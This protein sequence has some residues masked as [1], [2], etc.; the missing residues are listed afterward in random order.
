MMKLTVTFHNY[1]NTPKKGKE[2]DRKSHI[3]F[4]SQPTPHPRDI[5]CFGFQRDTSKALKAE[6]AKS[7]PLHMNVHVH[8]CT[9]WNGIWNS[10]RLVQGGSNMTG[11]NCDLFT[12]KQSQSCLNHLVFKN[13]HPLEFSRSLRIHLGRF[14]YNT[15]AKVSIIKQ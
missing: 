15:Y 10:V 4:H 1:A 12:H 8:A 11:T 13:H 3:T 9:S 7:E 6:V 2:W 5:T 14:Y